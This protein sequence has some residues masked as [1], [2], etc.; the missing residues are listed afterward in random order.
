MA[1]AVTDVSVAQ[2]TFDAA[3]TTVSTHQAKPNFELRLYGASFELRFNY[4]VRTD[5]ELL[6]DQGCAV[7]WL[8][9]LNLTL[10]ASP[11]PLYNDFFQFELDEVKIDMDDFGL[12]LKGGDLQLVAA[13]FEDA[14]K[15]FIREYLLGEMSA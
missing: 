9:D 4:S 12:D 13:Y 7:A 10:S 1:V 15:Q 11:R 14:L 5:P 8:R 6:T 2:A 3:A